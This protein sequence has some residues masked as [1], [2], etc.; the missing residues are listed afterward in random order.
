MASLRQY[1]VLLTWMFWQGGFTFYASVVVPIGTEVL[2]SAAEQGWITRQVTFFLNLSGGIALVVLAWDIGTGSDPSRLRIRL[3][4]LTWVLLAVTLVLLVWWHGQLD[5]YLDLSDTSSPRF[6][7]RR[8]FRS[9][10]KRYL[11]T[12]TVQW[13]IGLAA[14]FQTLRAWQGSETKKN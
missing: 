2:G 3:R 14:L 5:H 13:A 4:W 10:H 12:Q 9:L 8:A 1:L 11:W 7:D 6:L